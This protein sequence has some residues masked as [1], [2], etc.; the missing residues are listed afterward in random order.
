[1]R[2]VSIGNLTKSL[3]VMVKSMHSKHHLT[4]RRIY[5]N[6]SWLRRWIIDSNSRGDALVSECSFTDEHPQELGRNLIINWSSLCKVRDAKCSHICMC[7]PLRDTC[8]LC[9]E[10]KMLIL[11]QTRKVNKVT[12]QDD[13]EEDIEN[14]DRILLSTLHIAEAKYQQVFANEQVRECKE[15]QVGNFH[16]NYS[17]YVCTFGFA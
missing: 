3:H 14:E 17:R 9:F 8:N 4:K 2:H 11:K 7:S 10:F 15:D 1:M 5:R 6:C 16:F 13:N 12:N